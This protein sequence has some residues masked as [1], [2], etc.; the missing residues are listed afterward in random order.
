[1]ARETKVDRLVRTISENVLEHLHELKTIIANPN[2]KEFKVERFIQSFLR[3]CLGFS[4]SN[5]YAI[6]PQE[7]K[8]RH[9]PD[10][11][12]LKNDKPVPSR[13]FES[14]RRCTLGNSVERL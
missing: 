13:V 7:V 6:R 2:T 8:G 12:V 11:V 5:N 1:M 4:A 10:L 9:R 3:S 14:V